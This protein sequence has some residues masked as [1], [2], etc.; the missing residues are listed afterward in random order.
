MKKV[1]Y[2]VVNGR[3]D[4]NDGGVTYQP[5][6]LLQTPSSFPDVNSNNNKNYAYCTVKTDVYI[7]DGELSFGYELNHKESSFQIVLWSSASNIVFSF[8]ETGYLCLLKTWDGSKYNNIQSVG[9]VFSYLHAF[10]YKVKIVLKGGS[11][12]VFINE[13]EVIVYEHKLQGLKVDMMFVGPSEIKITNFS[14][15]SIEPK[16]F[17]VM[18]FCQMYDDLYEA[19]IKPVCAEFGLRTVRADESFNN[20]FIIHEI[21]SEIS[22]ATVIIAD[23]TPDNPNVYYE[24]GYAHALKKNVVL[25]CNEERVKL[26]FDLSGFRTIF[27]KNSIAGNSLVKQRLINH[28]NSILS[29]DV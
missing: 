19:V 16:C 13:V 14:V 15:R 18:Q 26:P 7:S 22:E 12:R 6:E 11:V 28:L 25:M 4:V 9:D 29:G 2:L 1:N 17:V 20:N 8:N 23:I 3:A 24:V 10:S 5:V 27:Y 21:V